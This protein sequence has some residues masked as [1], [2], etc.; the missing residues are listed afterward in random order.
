LNFALASILILLIVL[1]GILARY[2]YIKGTWKSPAILSSYTNELLSGISISIFINIILI[3]VIQ[4]SGYQID[5]YTIFSILTGRYSTD[6]YEYIIAVLDKYYLLILLYFICSHIFG[7]ISGLALHFLV[8]W[9]H[10]DIK[11]PL[12]KFNNNWYYMLSGENWIINDIQTRSL[13][14]RL[15]ISNKNIREIINSMYVV[16]SAVVTQGE[17]TFLYWGTVDNYQYNK[18][19]ELSTIEL[20]GAYRRLI[21]EDNEDNSEKIEPETDQRYYKIHGNSLIIDY[22]DMKT[23]N[24][25]YRY[26][27][28]KK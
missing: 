28:E 12:I 15:F 23:L 3:S 14:R 8:R 7:F 22:S 27:E 11:I 16:A 18:L 17:S 25:E 24:I 1:P 19:G 4:I 6:G 9:L 10:L 2:S 13:W 21:E 26:I 20:K 5:V